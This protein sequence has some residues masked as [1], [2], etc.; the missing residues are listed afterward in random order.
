MVSVCSITVM[1]L[2]IIQSVWNH[3]YFKPPCPYMCP[4]VYKP[5][6]GSDNVS[7]LNVCRMQAAACMKGVKVGLQHV[8][9]C[10][11]PEPCPAFCPTENEEQYCGSDGRSYRSMCHVQAAVCRGIG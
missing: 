3:P 6:C 9:R 1:V 11:V 8:G 7:Y 4:H 5:V 10:G 2:S